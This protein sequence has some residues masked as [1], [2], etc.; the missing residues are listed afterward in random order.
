VHI[1][2]KSPCTHSHRA[3]VNRLR[4]IEKTDYTNKLSRINVPT[5]IITLEQDRLIERQAA[6]II[7][8]PHIIWRTFPQAIWRSLRGATT[9]VLSRPVSML[10][11]AGPYQ[12][13]ADARTA[14]FRCVMRT[15]AFRVHASRDIAPRRALRPYAIPPRNVRES[16]ANQSPFFWVF[17]SR[18][19][20][21]SN[22]DPAGLEFVG[23]NRTRWLYLPVSPFLD[24]TGLR[25]AGRSP[26]REAG[27]GQRHWGRSTVSAEATPQRAVRPMAVIAGAGCDILPAN[28][29][30]SA[31]TRA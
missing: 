14:R 16:R 17:E 25:K 5:L 24:S 26:C 22:S 10:H 31:G 18:G 7:V 3:H 21:C 9:T 29:P 8:T 13:E 23:W 19:W 15:L 2:V 27:N 11:Q 6:E 4:S 20:K 12:P 28:A 30:P 1:W